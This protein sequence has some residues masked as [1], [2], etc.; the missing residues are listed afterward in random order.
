[1]EYTNLEVWIEARKLTNLVYEKTKKHP[2]EE[3]FGLTNQIRRCA[4]SV[5]SNVAEGCGR[6]TSNDTIQFLHIAKGS[7]FELETQI[8]LSLDQNYISETEFTEI[9]NQI[10]ICKKLINGF[11]NYYKKLNNAK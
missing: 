8:Y 2:K 4:V 9:S 1:M 10:L 3:L 6:R 11:I 5:P 7:L